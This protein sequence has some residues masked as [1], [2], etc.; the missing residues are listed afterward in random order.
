M[1]AYHENHDPSMWH[2]SWIP[3][4]DDLCKFFKDLEKM[5]EFSSEYQETGER[6]VAQRISDLAAEISVMATMIAENR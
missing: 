6:Y 1:T 2:P 3:T 5:E 4:E